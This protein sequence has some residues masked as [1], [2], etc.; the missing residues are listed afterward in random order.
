MAKKPQTTDVIGQWALVIGIVV[1]VLVGIGV[2]GTLTETAI[3]VLIVLGL[4]IG[5]LNVA[6]KESSAF[7]LA[8][9]ALLLVS[10]LGKNVVGVIAV[11]GSILDA[12][13]AVVV[14]A[15]IIVALREVFEIAK[16]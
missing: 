2:S 12:I 16:K 6:S 14:P 1:A 7:L 5:L 4:V 15:T 9:V 8:A 3:M 13:M 11:V 10:S